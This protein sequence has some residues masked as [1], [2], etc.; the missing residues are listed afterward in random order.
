M[1]VAPTLPSVAGTHTLLG[2]YTA[3]NGTPT[4]FPVVTI[5]VDC[6]VT[7]FTRPSDPS[8]IAYNLWDAPVYEDFT[9]DW[10]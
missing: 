7:S 10:V 3:T 8:S 9:Q 4:I 5:T 1:T 6:V 2:T